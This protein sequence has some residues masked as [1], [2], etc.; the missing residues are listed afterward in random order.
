MPKTKRRKKGTQN[1]AARRVV[2]QRQGKQE[3]PARTL[4]RSRGYARGGSLQNIIFAGMLTCGFLG[5]AI[6]FTFFYD[7]AN[8]YFYAGIAAL[9]AVGWA[10]LLAR[11]WTQYRQRA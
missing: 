10:L 8:R 2:E 3:A 11:R 6:F 4:Q 5:M 9:T 7:D 1:T